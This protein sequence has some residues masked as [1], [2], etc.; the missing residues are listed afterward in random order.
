[1]RK[2]LAL[3]NNE[4]LRIFM[5]KPSYNCIYIIQIYMYAKVD[6]L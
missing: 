6:E 3:I 1:M 5:L 4:K 2:S